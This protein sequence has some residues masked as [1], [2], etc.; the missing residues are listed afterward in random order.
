MEERR[1]ETWRTN[2][3][4]TDEQHLYNEV[5]ERLNE[6]CADYWVHDSAIFNTNIAF[7]CRRGSLGRQHF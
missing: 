5:V 6:A 2:K 1:T 7:Y 3:N 4:M